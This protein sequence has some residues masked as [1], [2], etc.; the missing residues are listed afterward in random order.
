MLWIELLVACIA[1]ILVAWI[2]IQSLR[3]VRLL[4]WLRAGAEGDAP[5]LSGCWGEIAN[6][7][8]RLVRAQQR[9]AQESD[10]RLQDFLAAL[11]V[12]PN[13]VVLLDAETGMEWFNHTAARHFGFD[14]Q[15]DTSQYIGN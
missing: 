7:T 6:R 14:A 5:E 12:S 9:L 13:G 4:H 3:A 11:Q 10:Q 15:R 1:I 2:A 8:R